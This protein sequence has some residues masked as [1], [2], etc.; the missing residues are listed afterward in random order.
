MKRVKDNLDILKV[1]S[2]GKKPIKKAILEKAD[3]ELVTYLCECAL[4]SIKG[5]VKMPKESIEKFKKSR[6]IIHKLLEKKRP[7]K[8]KRKILLQRGESIL[9]IIIPAV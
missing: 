5:N 2:I 3:G 6:R 4:N 1:L 7:I 8:E 9:P